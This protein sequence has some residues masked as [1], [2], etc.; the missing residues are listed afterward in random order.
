MQYHII[1]FVA[2]A[3]INAEDQ[4]EFVVDYFNL[5]EVTNVVA[6]T[7]NSKKGNYKKGI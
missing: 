1:F 4:H 7:C 5:K 2:F 3:I 6:L